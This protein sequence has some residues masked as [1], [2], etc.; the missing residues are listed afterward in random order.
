M[1][2]KDKDVTVNKVNFTITNKAGSDQYRI[3]VECDVE[4]STNPFEIV[5]CV[6]DGAMLL[7]EYTSDPEFARRLAAQRLMDHINEKKGQSQSQATKG[8]AYP[9]TNI[10]KA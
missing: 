4:P 7:S 10:A 3:D 2:K 5:Q 9:I 1:A 6:I 8:F